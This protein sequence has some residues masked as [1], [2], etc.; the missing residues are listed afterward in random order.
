MDLIGN[1]QMKLTQGNNL[2]LCEYLLDVFIFSIEISAGYANF[3]KDVINKDQK[4]RFK[5][6][7]QAL[8]LLSEQSGWKESMGKVIINMPNFFFDLIA[9]KFIFSDL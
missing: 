8:Q 2:E 1:I 6:F 4:Y 5:I 9:N 3:C 7:P